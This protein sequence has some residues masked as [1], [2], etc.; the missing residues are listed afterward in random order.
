MSL[1]LTGVIPKQ[2]SHEKST[3]PFFTNVIYAA[4]CCSVRGYYSL[5][6][7]A[8]NRAITSLRNQRSE[9]DVTLGNALIS[10][11]SA[12]GSISHG[13]HEL[14]GP[15]P[16]PA[17]LVSS[18]DDPEIVGDQMGVAVAPGGL[19]CSQRGSQDLQLSLRFRQARG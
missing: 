17:L 16:P 15:A 13:S 8:V 6:D 19:F 11:K 9:R 12:S 10:I 2:M 18:H 5:T 14:V 4:C 3:L 7:P 1:C